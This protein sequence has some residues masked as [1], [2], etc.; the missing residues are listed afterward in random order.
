MFA[1]FP[2]GMETTY[3]PDKTICFSA[4]TPFGLLNAIN[5]AFYTCAADVCW[6]AHVFI[7]ILP[8]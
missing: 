3:P 5:K 1:V 2:L 4:G 6:C 7:G 8:T